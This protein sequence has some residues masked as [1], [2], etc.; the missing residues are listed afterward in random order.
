MSG[1]D[2]DDFPAE[3]LVGRGDFL[4]PPPVASGQQA[5]GS[6]S[7][8]GSSPTSTGFWQRTTAASNRSGNASTDAPRAKSQ[9]LGFCPAI[10]SETAHFSSRR[11][12]LLYIARLKTIPT[13]ACTVGGVL[14]NQGTLAT[15]S[16]AKPA[17]NLSFRGRPLLQNRF[18]SVILR[19]V[20]LATGAWRSL[21]SAS[22][23]GS[24]GRK[25]KSCRPDLIKP[26]VARSYGGLCFRVDRA[27]NH[28]GYRG[29]T[30][31]R[32]TTRK[33]VETEGPN[34]ESEP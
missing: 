22:E 9:V 10:W 21:A 8:R 20:K 26:V 29:A 17:A 12:G 15:P 6:I 19:L 5:R 14:M 23:W 7:A 1:D 11:P 18:V 2:I 24:E 32:K 31:G 13:R 3:L 34:R 25:F 4:R 30:G 28:R 16:K 33:P 27:G